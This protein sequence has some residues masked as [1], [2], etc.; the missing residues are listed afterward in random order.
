MDIACVGANGYGEVVTV[1]PTD[2]GRDEVAERRIIADARQDAAPGSQRLDVVVQGGIAC[3]DEEQLHTLKV[4][5][6]ERPFDHG[7]RQLLQ[8]SLTSGAMTVA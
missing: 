3:T 6:L 2:G 1:L 4:A 5:L 8:A 7:K